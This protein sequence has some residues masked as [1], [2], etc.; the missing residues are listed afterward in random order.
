MDCHLYKQILEEDL[1]LLINHT[2]DKLGLRRDEVIFQH[3]SDPKHTSNLVKN[4]LL[5]QDYEVMNWP[6]QSPDLNPIENMWAL[7]KRRLNEYETAL[8]GI[9]DLS[10]RVTEVWYNTIKQEECQKV[11]DSMP[12]RVEVCLERNGLWTD[13]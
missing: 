10:E 8:K 9:L 6:P 5:D 1:E 7:L 11:I 4:H 13:Y 12:N 2:L 3:D